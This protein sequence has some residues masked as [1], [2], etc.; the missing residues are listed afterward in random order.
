[1]DSR[2]NDAPAVPSFID[3]LGSLPIEE[4]RT[5]LVWLRGVGTALGCTIAD[6]EILI[7]EDFLDFLPNLKP[8]RSLN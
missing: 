1:M 5:T 6:E 4:Q 3:I 7:A 2:E 8:A